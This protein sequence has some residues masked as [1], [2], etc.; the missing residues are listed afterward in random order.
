MMNAV[1]GPSEDIKGISCSHAFPRSLLVAGKRLFTK[2]CTNF[3]VEIALPRFFGYSTLWLREEHIKTNSAEYI[4]V[5]LYQ[6]SEELKPY[7]ATRPR[8]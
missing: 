7:T 2:L 3:F 8:L 4:A 5:F 6:I 1:A